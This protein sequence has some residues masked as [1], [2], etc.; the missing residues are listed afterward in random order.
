MLLERVYSVHDNRRNVQNVYRSG[1]NYGHAFNIP[2]STVVVGI[3][4]LNTLYTYVI[5]DPSDVFLVY[6]QSWSQNL[7]R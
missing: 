2:S 7:F 6:R 3:K 5:N 4:N 1:Q